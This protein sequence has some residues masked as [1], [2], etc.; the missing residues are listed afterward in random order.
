ML[1]VAACA[2][3]DGTPTPTGG[4]GLPDASP[5][6]S[7]TLGEVALFS[8][9]TP[10]QVR[11]PA[12]CATVAAASPEFSWEHDG[13]PGTGEER[14]FAAVFL[15]PPVVQ[16]DEIANTDRAVWW[17][18]TG[19]SR[20]TGQ[21]RDG[22]VRWS[23]GRGFTGGRSDKDA[24]A[25]SLEPGRWHY[26]AVWGWDGELTLSFASEIRAF[27]PGGGCNC[28]ASVDDTTVAD[29][30]CKPLPDPPASWSPGCI[31]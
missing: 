8:G 15:D 14:V 19:L 13:T 26:F 23:D 3:L 1:L 24:P 2:S 5:S 29:L 9:A 31:R 7:L 25:P 21:G 27:C 30:Y 28:D 10:L 22:Y 20:Q 18:S 12:R 6:T 11:M 4:N 16:S 17:W